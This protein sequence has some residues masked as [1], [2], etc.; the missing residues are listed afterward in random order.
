MSHAYLSAPLSLEVQHHEQLR[1]AV[2]LQ[3]VSKTENL[4][5]REKNFAEMTKGRGVLGIEAGVKR[6][7]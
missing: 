2:L 7:S 5:S 1:Q 6:V 4:S 3:S